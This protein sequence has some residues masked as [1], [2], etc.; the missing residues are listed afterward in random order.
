MNDLLAP[1][2]RSSNAHRRVIL[3]HN[4]NQYEAFIADDYGV[5]N[6]VVNYESNERKYESSISIEVLG[7]LIGDGKNQMQPRVVR[8]EN[9][10]QVRFARER[11]IMGDDED[12]EFR[13]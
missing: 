1:I 10:V 2:I 8:R 7:Y 6:T 4:N 9:A 13:F 12:G 3:T 11:V 5:K